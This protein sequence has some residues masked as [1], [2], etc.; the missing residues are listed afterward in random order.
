VLWFIVFLI[1]LLCVPICVLSGAIWLGAAA[2]QGL[3]TCVEKSLTSFTDGHVISAMLYLI[4]ATLL[5]CAI[6]E[7]LYLAGSFFMAVIR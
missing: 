2:V 5:L 3:L 4:P 6:G 7:G 1:G